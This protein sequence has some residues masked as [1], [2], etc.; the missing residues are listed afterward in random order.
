M[1]M[2]LRILPQCSQK[3]DFSQD[4]IS[5]HRDCK[6]FKLINEVEK[7]YGREVPGDGINSY[8]GDA[9]KTGEPCYGK[10]LTDSYGSV[11]KG[12]PAGELKKTLK[13]FKDASWK[14]KAFIAFLNE[15]PDDLEIWLYWH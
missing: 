12:V 10:T 2:D 1:G 11:I 4:I 15:L 8:I 9:E 6:L 14:N 13:R 5:L 7:K 3:T